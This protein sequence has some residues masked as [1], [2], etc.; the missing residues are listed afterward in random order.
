[1]QRGSKSTC[2]PNGPNVGAKC[3]STTNA[4]GVLLGGPAC[5]APLTCVSGACAVVPQ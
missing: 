1:V 2:V 5:E 4:N 3:S